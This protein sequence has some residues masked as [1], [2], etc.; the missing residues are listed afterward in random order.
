MGSPRP[1]PP[2]ARLTRR[3]S[4]PTF[5][6]LLGNALSTRGLPSIAGYNRP[7]AVYLYSIVSKC[8]DSASLTTALPTLIPLYRP[9]LTI[10]FPGVT[11]PACCHPFALLPRSLALGSYPSRNIH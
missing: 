10:I 2:A 4:I 9:R 8:S 1:S 7:W 3:L 6:W 5:T 11:L